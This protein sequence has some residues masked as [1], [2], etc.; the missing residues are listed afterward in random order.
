MQKEGSE[1]PH[2]ETQRQFAI[3]KRQST[4][5]PSRPQRQD[6]KRGTAD[7]PANMTAD[8]RNTGSPHTKTTAGR[9]QTQ[10]ITQDKPRPVHAPKKKRDELAMTDV[11]SKRTA[12]AGAHPATVRVHQLLQLRLL[13]DPELHLVAFTVAH[14][15]LAETKRAR[16]DKKYTTAAAHER[17]S[18]KKSPGCETSLQQK[19]H[20]QVRAHSH[21]RGIDGR[22]KPSEREREEY[23]LEMAAPLP[24]AAKPRC[25]PPHRPC[26]S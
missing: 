12:H 13:L 1:A 24:T 5:T 23:S 20:M 17:Q 26:P 7:P 2:G 16:N 22:S 4:R 3:A 19:N 11:P 18:Q 21:P 9:Q 14:L 15:G 8:P 25:R 10:Q 6:T